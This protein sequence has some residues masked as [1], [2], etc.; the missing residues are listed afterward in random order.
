MHLTRAQITK[1]VPIA[2]KGTRYIAR[3]LSHPNTAVSVLSA[4]RD[5]LKLARTAR[6][7][8]EMIKQKQIKING[9][10]VYDYH[11]PVHMLGILDADKRYIL[12]ILPTN[13]FS[14]E[15]TKEKTRIAKIINKKTLNGG[16]VQ[17]N[18]HEGTNVVTKSKANVGD[19]VE[20]DMDNKIV[21]VL[22]LGKGKKALLIYGRNVGVKGTIKEVEGKM[23]ILEINGQQVK[24]SREQ[25]I[26][27]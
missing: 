10:I 21:N 9:R 3:P 20:L 26:V 8:K 17:L 25:V 4:V 2:R 6:E 5:I 15:E 16:Q 23:L 18:M 12:T 27:L 13:R 19:S 7:V 22:P 1:R 11:A 14:L 24:A